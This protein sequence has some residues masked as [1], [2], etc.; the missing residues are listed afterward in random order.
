VLCI[1][2]SGSFFMGSHVCVRAQQTNTVTVSVV[3][4]ELLELG[5]DNCTFRGNDAG[6]S[7]LVC[8]RFFWIC[9]VS[10]MY[11]AGC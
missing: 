6:V 4:S 8:F 11:L 9:R 2:N 7:W 3:Q 1:L 10:P 5:F